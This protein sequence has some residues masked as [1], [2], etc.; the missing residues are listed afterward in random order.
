MHT[1]RNTNTGT[2]YRSSLENFFIELGFGTD[3]SEIPIDTIRS[4]A[5]D[6]LVKSSCIFLRQ[7]NLDLHHDISSNPLRLGDELIKPLLLKC[8]PSLEDAHTLNRCRLY[9]QVLY[10]SEICSGDG[11]M[12]TND[13]WNGIRFDVPHKLLPWPKQQRPSPRE[14]TIWQ[15]YIW[16]VLLAR[17]LRLKSPLGR[18]LGIDDTW[19]WYYSPSHERL[20][21]LENAAWKS[22]SHIIKCNKLPAFERSRKN[23]S[24]PTDI[25]RATV[26]M[27]RDRIECT[28]YDSI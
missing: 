5:T 17:G 11:Q 12:I 1:F 4:T 18:W 25:C 28:G 15:R 16:R 23:D 20:F 6:S 27:H 9:L 14:W 19:E 13:A 2:L 8:H 21:K 7:H 22:F 10:V 26:Y 24:P 3:I